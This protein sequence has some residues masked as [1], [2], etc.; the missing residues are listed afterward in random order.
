MQS[1]LSHVYTQIGRGVPVI[2]HLET[3]DLVL[4]GKGDIHVVYLVPIALHDRHL[5]V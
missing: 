5:G 2:L 1:E 3:V 4:V